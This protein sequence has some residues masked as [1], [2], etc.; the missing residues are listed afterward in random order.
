MSLLSFALVALGI[1]LLYGGGEALVRG[2]VDLARTL[3]LSSMVIGLTVVAFAT[4]APELAATLM[5][6]L[7]EAPDL[8]IGNALGSNIAN[9]GLILGIA[10]LVA[11]LQAKAQFL[12]REI[13]LLLG[14]TLVLYPIM[15]DGMIGR[16]EGAILM[17]MLGGYLYLLLNENEPI[18]VHEEFQA[19]AD[20]KADQRSIVVAMSMVAGGV[21]LLVLGAWSLVTGAVQIALAMGLPERVV[22]LTMVAFGTSLPELASSIVAA[23]RK[24]GDIVL[25]NIIGSNVFNILCI[26]GITSM[27]H[28][29]P[30]S[31]E[32]QRVDY[33][34]VLGFSVIVIP[35]LLPRLRL[36]RWQGAFLVLLYCGYMA[37]LFA[38]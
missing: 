23:R 29:I 16:V 25:G 19:S 32:T 35:L 20:R 37:W 12:K 33:W 10:A 2:A 31:T 17:L 28:P 36:G 4:S 30:V 27:I 5:A 1:V 18:E 9:L 13:P 24:E 26:L 38:G 7:Q 21:G 11:P 6:T 3:G 22:G 15:G 8:A 34:V 14:A